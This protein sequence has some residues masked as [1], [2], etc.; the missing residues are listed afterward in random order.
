MNQ[1]L[2]IIPWLRQ[3]SALECKKHPTTKKTPRGI[4]VQ[5]NSLRAQ[6]P[7]AILSHHDG[8]RAR[9]KPSVAPVTNGHCGACHLAISRGRLLDLQ[10][11][12]DALNICDHCRVFIYLAEEEHPTVTSPPPTRVTNPAKKSKARSPLSSH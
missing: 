11:N 2:N 1:S 4:V 7:T 10:R 9:R 5:I 3:L 6:M 12:P 8:L